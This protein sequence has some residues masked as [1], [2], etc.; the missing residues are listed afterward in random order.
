VELRKLRDREAHVHRHVSQRIVD[1]VRHARRERPHRRHAIGEHEARF[2]ALGRADVA[3]DAREGGAALEVGEHDRAAFEDDGLA[4]LAQEAQLRRLAGSP[5]ALG[6]AIAQER[7]IALVLRKQVQHRAS[8]DLR[9][10]GVPEALGECSVRVDDRL[11]APDDH[12]GG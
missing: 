3:D 12:P 9:R 2:H 7:A 6:H 4:V 10:V 1:L 8:D 11:P 5:L